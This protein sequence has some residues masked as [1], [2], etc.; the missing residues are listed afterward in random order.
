MKKWISYLGVVFCMIVGATILSA[1]NFSVGSG[2]TNPT[3]DPPKAVVLP[4]DIEVSGYD[5][6][7]VVGDDFIDKLKVKIYING[8]W[9]ELAKAD[10]QY[11]TTYDGTKYGEYSFNVYLKEYPNIEFSDTI[12][13]KPIKVDIP[14][15]YSTTYD[16][17]EVDIKSYYNSQSNGLYSVFSYVNMAN[18]GDYE[19]QLKLNNSDKYAWSNASG[20]ILSNPIQKVKWSITKADRKQYTGQ[21]DFVAYFGDTLQDL[22][23]DNNLKNITWYMDS[24]GKKISNTTSIAKGVS[25]YAYYN[26]N[27]QNYEDTLITITISD[28]ITTANYTVNY[29]VFDGETY[30]LNDEMTVVT[31]SKIGTIVEAQAPT[32]YQLDSNKSE[33]KGEVTKKDGLVLKVYVIPNE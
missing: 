13:V 2:N 11:A 16:G 9:Q 25:Y 7:I 24:N 6:E 12:T 27:P 1:C 18:C 20:E 31:S 22:V 21:V 32:G 8:G 17:N 23:Y 4:T 3:A 5:K 29:Y 26:E 30:N 19:V 28:V 15:E 33:T 14:S 10:Y